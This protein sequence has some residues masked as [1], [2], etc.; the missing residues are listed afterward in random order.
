MESESS[1]EIESPEDA[2]SLFDALEFYADPQNWTGKNKEYVDSRG[3][4]KKVDGLI[5]AEVFNDRGI[6]ARTL[7]GYFKRKYGVCVSDRIP[8]TFLERPTQ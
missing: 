2:K 1:T 8:D 7:L 6:R 3:V 4:L 5:H